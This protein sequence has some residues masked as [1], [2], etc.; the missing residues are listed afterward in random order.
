MA[1]CDACGERTAT[2]PMCEDCRAETVAAIAD[3]VASGQWLGPVAGD[4]LLLL[5]EVDRL[6]AE[7]ARRGEEYDAVRAERDAAWEDLARVASGK[8]LVALTADRDRLAAQVDG[9]RELTV[10]ALGGVDGRTF[11]IHPSKQVT[12][13]QIRAALDS[14]VPS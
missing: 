11:D 14:E 9:V 2:P 12:V 10:R 5:A 8:S 4:L 3:R 6:R 13:G 7:L 1:D